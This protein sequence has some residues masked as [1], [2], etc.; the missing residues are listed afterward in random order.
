MTKGRACSS[1]DS[2]SFTYAIIRSRLQT[3][4]HIQFLNREE[5]A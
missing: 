4:K 3:T 2:Q 1:S 5:A